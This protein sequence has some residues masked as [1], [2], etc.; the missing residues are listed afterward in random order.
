MG[1]RRHSLSTPQY[2]G[3]QEGGRGPEVHRGYLGWNKMEGFP[4]EVIP[5]PS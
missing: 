2:A 1:D 5:V 4:E 3:E